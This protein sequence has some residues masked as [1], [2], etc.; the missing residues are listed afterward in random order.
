MLLEKEFIRTDV[1]ASSAHQVIELLSGILVKGGRVKESFCVACEERE[2]RYP[3]GIPAAG[4][5]LAIPHTTTDHV[6]EPA[7]AVARLQNGVRF[8]EMGTLD[9]PL[10][11]EL[12]IMLAVQN[13]NTQLDTLQR[14]MAVFQDSEVLRQIRECDTVDGLHQ[15]LMFLN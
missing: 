9:T 15:L 5:G 2:T 3:T 13:P 6:I 4:I 14:L 7:I 10:D 8:T 12:V 1:N 11:V